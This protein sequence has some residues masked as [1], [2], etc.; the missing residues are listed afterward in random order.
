MKARVLMIVL[1]ALVL[2]G[3][4]HNYNAAALAPEAAPALEMGAGSEPVVSPIY[5]LQPG[6]RVTIHSQ[7]HDQLSGDATVGPDGQLVVPSVG[8]FQA[9]GL[10]ADELG[11]E[12]TRRAALTYRQP[13]INVA[14]KEY[15]NY[16]AYI[17]GE[18][19]KPGYVIL[20]PGVTTIRAVMERGGFT[21]GARLDSVLH[22]AW[23]AQ[24]GYSA[25]RL[26][27]RRVLETG[28]TSQDLALG[29]N[30][31][32]YVP[33]TWITNADLWVRQWI[34]DLIPIR[35]PTVRPLGY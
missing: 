35:E 6:D 22:I 4:F 13:Q 27:L 16:R 1:P 11:A 25:K 14:V 19:K 24:G 21:Y 8:A 31:V 10:T 29:P 26:D 15:T 7:F 34:V 3:C 5:R 18:V 32:I 28:D 30:D 9:V 17:G 2:S 33:A 12:I 20:K 23:N